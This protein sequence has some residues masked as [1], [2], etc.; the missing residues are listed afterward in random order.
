MYSAEVLPVFDK[1]VSGVRVV[2]VIAELSDATVLVAGIRPSCK[3]HSCNGM[4][5]HY[6]GK[7]Q[8]FVLNLN[9]ISTYC[10]SLP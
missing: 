6:N 10:P 1:V 3:H 5:I 8:K 9:T 7:V 4:N 2:S